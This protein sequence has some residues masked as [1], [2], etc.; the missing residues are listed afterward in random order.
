MSTNGKSV[1]SSPSGVCDPQRLMGFRLLDGS[2]MAVLQ[3]KRGDKRVGVPVV[4]LGM[5]Q[6]KKDVL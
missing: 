5:K 1:H 4:A 2:R 6:G 3:A